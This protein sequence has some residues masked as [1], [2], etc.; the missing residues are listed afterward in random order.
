MF[1]L[2]PK[3]CR[4]EILEGLLGADLIG[5][6]THDYVQYFLRCVTYILGLEH[7]MRNIF[8]GERIV[9]VD[10]FPMG[11]DFMKFYNAVNSPEVQE[12]KQRL[13]KTLSEVKVV[14]SVDRLD[15]TKGILNRLKGFELFLQQNAHWHGKVVMILISVPS[16]IGIE[17]YQEMKRQIDEYVGKINGRFGKIDWTPIIYQFRFLPFHPLVALYSI[18]DVALITPLRD[19]MNLVAKEFLATKTDQTGVLILSETAGAAKELGE[20]II[21]NPNS[22]EDIADSLKRALEMPKEEQIKHNRIMQERLKTYDVIRWAEDFIQEML[23]VKEEQ[24]RF[25]AKILDNTT[26]EK[27]IKDFNKNKT[28][29]NL[30]FLDY[31]G[32]LVPF[33][34]NYEE[35]KPDEELLNIIYQLSKRSEVVLIS[36]RD[37]NTLNNWFDNANIGL[38]AEHG[39]W[40]K[41]KGKDK[42]KDKDKGWRLI[43]PLVAD[44]K[45]RLLPILKIYVDRLPGS[46]IEEKEFSLVWHYRKADPYLASIRSKELVDELVHFTSNVDLQV[47]QGSKVVEIRNSGVNKGTA[48]M[49]FLSKGDFNFILA[50]GD[51][52]TDEDLFRILPQSSYSIRVGFAPSYAKYNLQNHLEVRALLKELLK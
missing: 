24:K 41:E 17:H 1:R 40:I 9:K 11:I 23:L 34:K 26:L 38:V 39:V 29:Q 30:I 51:D 36:G 15:Y 45:T 37:R 13:K 46:F 10:A 3:R 7:N 12:E 2:L 22:I 47:L 28:S 25:V 14:V 4:K 20:A 33:R 42:D 5:F 21:A 31:D 27:L 16:R 44:W 48:A 8:T 52:W 6:H 19:G 18:S 50:I 35:A 32:T 49:H 43:K